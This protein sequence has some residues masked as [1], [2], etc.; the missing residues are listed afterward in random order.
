M[1]LRNR[2]IEL[3]LHLHLMAVKWFPSNFSAS[4]SNQLISDA[5]LKIVLNT[6]IPILLQCTLQL[7]VL[8]VFQNIYLTLASHA[9]GLSRGLSICIIT[10]CSLGVV[11]FIRRNVIMISCFRSVVSCVKLRCLL[12]SRCC[13]VSPDC[14][15]MLY[16]C[17]TRLSRLCWLYFYIVR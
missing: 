9:T 13:E 4:D 15:V 6:N 10:L 3:Q 16:L 5:L 8:F 2:A 17:F 1:C 14:N 7:L 12:F 11:L